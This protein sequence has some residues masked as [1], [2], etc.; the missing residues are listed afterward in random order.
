MQPDQYPESGVTETQKVVRVFAEGKVMVA[1]EP[2]SSSAMST[3][4]GGGLE[5]GGYVGCII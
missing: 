1:T 3:G 5:G 4:G 2:P